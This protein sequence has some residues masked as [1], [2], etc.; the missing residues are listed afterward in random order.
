M[1]IFLCSPNA[2][3]DYNYHRRHQV[4]GRKVPSKLYL[5]SAA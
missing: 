1:M 2:Y 4:I 3:D 5:R